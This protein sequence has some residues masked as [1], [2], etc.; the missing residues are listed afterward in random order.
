[1][2]KQVQ[3]TMVPVAADAVPP[4]DFDADLRA[5]YQLHEY[6]TAASGTMVLGRRQLPSAWSKLVVVELPDGPARE[7]EWGPMSFHRPSLSP[8][9]DKALVSVSGSSVFEIDLASSE[10]Q[11]LWDTKQH[12]APLHDGWTPISQALYAVHDQLLFT[13]GSK[14]VLARRAGDGIEPVAALAGLDRHFAAATTSDGRH[15]VFQHPSQGFLVEIGDGTLTLVKKWPKKKQPL[16]LRRGRVF[17]HDLAT[18]TWSELM[19]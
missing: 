4:L 8:A 10:A 18:D 13:T 9:G 1:M 7:I 15:A 16:H 6:V 14:P 2:A 12:G 11:P 17:L 19:L 5:R 3:L